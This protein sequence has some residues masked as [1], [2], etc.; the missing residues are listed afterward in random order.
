MLLLLFAFLLVRLLWRSSSSAFGATGTDCLFRRLLLLLS[1]AASGGGILGI[2]RYVGGGCICE[3]DEE[4][5]NDMGR[6]LVVVGLVGGSLTLLL[7]NSFPNRWPSVGESSFSLAMSSLCLNDCR[8]PFVLTPIINLAV[9]LSPAGSRLRYTELFGGSS[10]LGL[11]GAVAV[12]LLGFL[13][14]LLLL[15]VLSSDKGGRLCDNFSA[16]DTVADGGLIW[17][18]GGFK[19]WS[20]RRGTVLDLVNGLRMK[21]LSLVSPPETDFFCTGDWSLT[22]LT[23]LSLGVCIS[24]CGSFMCSMTGCK[25]QSMGMREPW[26]R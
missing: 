7:L 8:R 9:R 6:F 18:C 3:E 19:A 20:M 25:M 5:A 2:D 10:L 14:L 13:V 1:G 16:V 22:D 17:R 15:L 24:S 26:L 23:D 4:A 21:L 11:L 12:L